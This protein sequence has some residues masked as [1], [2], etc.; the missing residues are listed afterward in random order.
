MCAND[1]YRSEFDRLNTPLVKQSGEK[2]L[3][4]NDFTQSAV[5]E[6]A[7]A[8]QLPVPTVAERVFLAL[9]REWQAEVESIP[10][11]KALS[12]RADHLAKTAL[13]LA[14]EWGA[15]FTPAARNEMEINRALAEARREPSWVD[16]LPWQ[17]CLVSNSTLPVLYELAVENL[18]SNLDHHSSSIRCWMMELG[19][20]TATWLDPVEATVRLLN[21]LG[22]TLMRPLMAAGLAA[23]FFYKPE[24]FFEFAKT[25]TPPQGFED[26]YQERLAYVEKKGVLAMQA[27]LWR[28]EALCRKEIER[29]GLT[30]KIQ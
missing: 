7:E 8:E 11:E 10:K 12:A 27:P 17:L 28:S 20:F 15:R 3:N 5:T 23:R 4:K 13:L 14:V 21:N 18:T 2:S 9:A 26:Q 22:N 6:R 24:G 29:V 19:W 25:F 30:L 16:E 1:K